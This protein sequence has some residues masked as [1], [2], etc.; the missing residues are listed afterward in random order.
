MGEWV[1]GYARA[2][3]CTTSAAVELWA[4][5]DGL[6]VH[7]KLNLPIM[8]VELDAKLV[9]DL[10]EKEKPGLNGNGVLVIDYEERLK[11][12]LRVRI[13]HCF[14]ESN[15]C[16]N[17]LARRDALLTNDFVIFS[18]PP[19]H[20]DVLLLANLDAIETMYQCYCSNVTGFS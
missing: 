19:P 7:I 14:R 10:L 11:Q 3:G 4:L 1:S 6:N 16:A 8:E 20:P 5:R 15:K 18:P 9:V 13:L 12:I 17:A 2:I